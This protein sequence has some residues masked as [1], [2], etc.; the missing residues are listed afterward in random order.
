MV[1]ATVF[2]NQ[3][4]GMWLFTNTQNWIQVAV[5]LVFTE[6]VLCFLGAGLAGMGRSEHGTLVTQVADG[7]PVDMKQYKAQREQSISQG[8]RLAG[9][10]VAL[11]ALAFMLQLLSP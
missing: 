5:V 9:I 6:A 2:F 4:Q 7:K 8:L 1:A 10:G 11:I 3:A